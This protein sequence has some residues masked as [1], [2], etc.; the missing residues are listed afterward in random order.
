M[1]ID[2]PKRPKSGAATKATT[3]QRGSAKPLTV[4][5]A[6]IGECVCD[7]GFLFADMRGLS[8]NAQFIELHGIEF[9]S[10][11]AM[12]DE[13]TPK[14]R[15]QETVE[16][17][18]NDTER[19]ISIGYLVDE[20]YPGDER[21][22]PEK[23]KEVRKI[24]DTVPLKVWN[25]NYPNDR[26]YNRSVAR[27]INSI[28]G[29]EFD[30]AL[31]E[32]GKDLENQ[33]KHPNRGTNK[34]LMGISAHNI[35]VIYVLAGKDDQALPLFRQALTM[36]KAA[37]GE[38]HPEVA[39]SL[40]E[41]GI[42]LFAQQK[43]EEALQTFNEVRKIRKSLLKPGDQKV[44]MVLNNIGCCNFQ[45]GNHLAALVTFQ[46]AVDVLQLQPATQNKSD[47]DL[48]HHA[49]TLCNLGYMKLHLKRYD[50][51]QEVFQ[52]ALMIQ[53]SVLGDNAN[54]RA[55]K[56]TLNNMAFTNAFHS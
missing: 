10:L 36:K 30:V 48:L 2:S 50:D 12:A 40:D 53:R 14:Q 42:Q 8:P 22:S 21:K 52:E 6:L 49:M 13:L 27:T 9:I 24:T 37:F 4:V 15:V 39:L 18:L 46:E 32:L 43:F 41:I 3:K 16:Q 33:K 11:G 26:N 34:Y 1:P 25:R 47:L 45:M 29:Q 17:L 19:L 7:P 28:K 35:G 54:N 55:V 5:Q 51:A 44:A 31:K 56:D 38:H 20:E 23:N